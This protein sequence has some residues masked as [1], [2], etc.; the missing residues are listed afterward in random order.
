[1]E[2]YIWVSSDREIETYQSSIVAIGH[3]LEEARGNALDQLG[4]IDPM[5]VVV[6]GEPD[7]TLDIQP[8][9]VVIE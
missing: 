4:P 6:D 5:R 2:V 8:Q 1:M 9:A 7:H 3:D